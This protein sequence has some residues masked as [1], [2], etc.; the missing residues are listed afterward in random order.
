MR[1]HD[2]E[3][4]DSARID[5]IIRGCHCCRLGFADGAHCYIVPVSFGFEH[6]A[7]R[8]FYFHSAREGRKLSLARSLRRAGFELDCGYALHEVASPCKYSCAFQSVI[9][10]GSIEE[11]TDRAEKLHALAAIL[12]HTAGR[13]GPWDF[14][15]GAEDTVAVLRLTVET[16][17]CKV[18]D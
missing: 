14:P 10:E 7:Q 15:P 2:R 13:K 9:G 4:L 16:L 5:E 17:S 8:V 3:I 12:S 6:G 18:H 11:V 1:R